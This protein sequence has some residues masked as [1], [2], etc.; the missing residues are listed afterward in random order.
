[1]SIY[2][3][4]SQPSFPLRFSLLPFCV[5]HSWLLVLTPE[6]AQGLSLGQS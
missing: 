1:M 6:T 3:F 4:V 5:A 2:W